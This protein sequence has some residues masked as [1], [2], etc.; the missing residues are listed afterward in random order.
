MKLTLLDMHGHLLRDLDLRGGNSLSLDRKGLAP[1][2]YF[3]LLSEDGIPLSSLKL[4][5]P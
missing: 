4:L 2:I 5:V 3:L 1:G